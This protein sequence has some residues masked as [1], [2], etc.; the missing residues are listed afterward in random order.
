LNAGESQYVRLGQGA[1]PARGTIPLPGY[2]WGYGQRMKSAYP[3]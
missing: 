1:D 3:K 2:I